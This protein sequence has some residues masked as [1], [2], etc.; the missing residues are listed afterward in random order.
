[1]STN[2]AEE[3]VEIVDLDNQPI[4]AITR[5]IMREQGLIHRAA[6]ILVFNDQG[7]LFLQ[8][9]TPSKDI[10]PC[11]WDMAAGGVVLAGESY[12][13]TAR[14]E[15]QEELGISARLRH[16]CDQYYEEPGNRVWGRIFTCTHNGPFTL[17]AAEIDAGRFIAPQLIAALNEVEPVTPDGLALLPRLL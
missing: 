13:V 11:Y 9:R 1:M 14:R 4:G 15:L 5:R 8:K 7:E 2:P 10:Y 17:Q 12:K 6:Y 16:L 3:L